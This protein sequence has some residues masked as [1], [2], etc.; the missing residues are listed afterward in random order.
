MPWFRSLQ[1]GWFIAPMLYVYGQHFHKFCI[2]HL[3]FQCNIF[4][5][6]TLNGLFWFIFPVSTVIFNDISAY[7]CGI[8]LGR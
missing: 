6:N 1:W 3:V 7:L 8:S 4:A 2:E 5:W